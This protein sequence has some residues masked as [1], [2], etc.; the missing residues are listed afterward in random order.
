MKAE[1]FESLK[2]EAETRFAARLKTSSASLIAGE[3]ASYCR[4]IFQ[5]F[6]EYLQSVYPELPAVKEETAL[7][8][9][10][11]FIPAFSHKKLAQYLYLTEEILYTGKTPLASDLDRLLILAKELVAEHKIHTG[12]E[13]DTE[14]QNDSSSF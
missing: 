14:N 6:T 12:M 2:A 13:R 9:L 5:A 1:Q 3:Y 11:P 8:L 7:S 10:K 4:N